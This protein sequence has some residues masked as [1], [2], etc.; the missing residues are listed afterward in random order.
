MIIRRLTCGIA[1]ALAALATP[2]AVH[3]QEPSEFT[4]VRSTF[5]VEPGKAS[6]FKFTLPAYYRDGR[7]A[8]NALAD[9]GWRDDIRVLILTARQFEAW[10]HDAKSETLFNSGPRRSVVLSVPVTD[11]GTYYVVFDNRFSTLSAKRV[12]ADIRF[13]HGSADSAPEE[14]AG[15]QCRRAVAPARDPGEPRHAGDPGVASEPCRRRRPG[16]R[17]RARAF[18]PLLSPLHRPRALA[19]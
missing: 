10:A 14:D 19:G 4:V 15:D 12:Q 6:R 2:R 7:I 5:R 8:G 18:A 3:A 17:A 11:P 9:G 1:L 16:R 13:V